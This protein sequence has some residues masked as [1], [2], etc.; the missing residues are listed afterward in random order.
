MRQLA[1]SGE[2]TP[3]GGQKAQRV[4]I[5]LL[6][7]GIPRQSGRGGAVSGEGRSDRLDV[8]RDDIRGP[9]SNAIPIERRVGDAPDS[10]LK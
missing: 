8:A 6:V 5:E 2:A 3:I 7:S 4:R 9:S 1:C 10:P